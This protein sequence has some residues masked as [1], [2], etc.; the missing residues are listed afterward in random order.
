MFFSRVF[1]VA[2]NPFPFKIAVVMAPRRA[3][4][5]HAQLDLVNLEGHDLQVRKEEG[6][7]YPISELWK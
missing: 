7:Q 6:N 4:L 1:C 5:P 3:M 2:K